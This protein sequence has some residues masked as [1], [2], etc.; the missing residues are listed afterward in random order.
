MLCSSAL[1]PPEDN[2]LL[3]NIWL[4][5][6]NAFIYIDTL[7]DQ[8]SLKDILHYNFSA[9]GQLERLSTAKNGYWINGEWQ[10]EDPTQTIF[11][12]QEV[13]IMPREE[14]G[15]HF[16]FQPILHVEMSLFSDEESLLDLYR[17]IQYR[18]SVGLSTSR[19]I[20]AFWSRLFQPV[21]TLIMMALAVPFVFGSLRNSSVSVRM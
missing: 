1:S 21:T 7:H 17:T 3:H 8:H 2:A 14:H 16:A 9:D 15:L 19:Q 4:H 11:R 10:L 18:H 5:H 20:S 13:Q 6:D 12:D